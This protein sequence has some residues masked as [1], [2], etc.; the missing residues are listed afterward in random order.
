MKVPVRVQYYHHFIV[1]HTLLNNNCPC[2]FLDVSNET[3]TQLVFGIGEFDEYRI[4]SDTVIT[5]CLKE[6]RAILHLAEVLSQPINIHFD[7]PGR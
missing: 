4:E 7:R 1:H 6:L 2:Y 5:F 3:R